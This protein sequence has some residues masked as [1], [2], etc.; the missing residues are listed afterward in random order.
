MMYSFLEQEKIKQAIIQFTVNLAGFLLIGV[1]YL[2]YVLLKPYARPLFWAAVFSVPLH[3]V[4]QMIVEYLGDSADR[5]ISVVRVF[6][7][8]LKMTFKACFGPV[9]TFLGRIIRGYLTLVHSI[10]NVEAPPLGP[11]EALAG[12]KSVDE[13]V[14]HSLPHSLS[15][16]SAEFHDVGSV[17]TTPEKVSDVAAD[18]PGLPESWA[19]LADHE[20]PTRPHSFVPVTAHAPVSTILSPIEASPLMSTIP[21]PLAASPASSSSSSSS[22]HDPSA[23]PLDT[24]D[25]TASPDRSGSMHAVHS[26]D[27]LVTP[28][29]PVQPHLAGPFMF[30]AMPMPTPSPVGAPPVL[31]QTRA[32]S[33]SRSR[34][35][36]GSIGSLNG[37]RSTLWPPAPGFGT[38]SMPGAPIANGNASARRRGTA[39]KAA[40]R[41]L[42]TGSTVGPDGLDDTMSVIGGTPRA[43]MIGGGSAAQEDDPVQLAADTSKSYMSLLLRASSLYLVAQLYHWI[44]PA[45]RIVMAI[46]FTSV[47]LAHLAWHILKRIYLLHLR[48]RLVRS[49]QVATAKLH[50]VDVVMGVLWHHTCDMVASVGVTRW[51]HV[52]YKRVKSN[53]KDVVVNNANSFAALFV[54]TAVLL[55]G[56]VL[57]AFLIFKVLQEFHSIMEGTITALDSSMSEDVRQR[58]QG[59]LEDGSTM[60]LGWID[61]KVAETWPNVNVTALYQKLVAKA[62]TSAAPTLSRHQLAKA[63]VAAGA[64]NRTALAAAAAN[65]TTLDVIGNGTAVLAASLPLTDLPFL[66]MMPETA[67]LIEHVSHGNFGA[68]T[69]YT[70]VFGSLMELKASSSHMVANVLK[71][72]TTAY[73]STF[74]T[75]A[76]G[77]SFSVLLTVIQLCLDFFGLIFQ[78]VMF[79]VTLHALLSR[80]SSI[81]D[82]FAQLL[83]MADP[84]QEFTASLEEN[85]NAVLVCTTKLTVFHSVLT[86]LTFSVFGVELVYLTTLATAFFCVVP[87][88]APMWL[89]VPGVLSL[90]W[91]Q[92]FW[93]ATALATIHFAASWFVD[94]AFFAEIPDVNPYF[95]ALAFL[96]GLYAF[97]LEGLVLGP[98]LMSVLPSLLA[99]LTKRAWE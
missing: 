29:P 78:V 40:R 79:L 4:K 96:L 49:L 80:E 44:A 47:V 74:A 48:K 60:A 9:A 17:R 97:G 25:G 43:S 41:R 62:A 84:E 45:N 33:R 77:M 88:I 16:T 61:G 26:I 35:R 5:D 8:G 57:T 93:S 15:P 46:I 89:A 94:P 83:I 90:Y 95:S 6:W 67:M 30:G 75:T 20:S 11:S 86:W 64:A 59:V 72:S 91:Q 52:K 1:A 63:V 39:A 10:S 70:A 87:L 53:S 22:P 42:F 27:H 24:A 12:K 19:D 13:D 66:A 99:L 32:L 34:S 38:M 85:I 69:N 36:R 56:T 71:S 98:L 18:G 14:P 28:P 68:L 23:R 73:L 21:D 65:G 50:P 82:L 51:V 81:M 54:L 7:L 92:R 2:N 76:A 58:V 3:A 31:R 55:V 37:S